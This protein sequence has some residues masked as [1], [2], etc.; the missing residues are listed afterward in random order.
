MA[1]RLFALN[2]FSGVSTRTIC[3]EAGM[4]PAAVNYHFEQIKSGY[5]TKIDFLKL[6]K[7]CGG[8]LHAEN[9]FG[10]N[11]DSSLIYGPVNGRTFYAGARL[12]IT[13]PK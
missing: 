5:L 4:S 8:L 13:N 1:E 6:Y 7:K 9:P 11:F 3:S 10:S 12:T 2:G